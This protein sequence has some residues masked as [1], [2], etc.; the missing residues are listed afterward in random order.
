MFSGAAEHGIDFLLGAGRTTGHALTN[1]PAIIDQ[2]RIALEKEIDKFVAE[3]DQRKRR[4]SL[5]LNQYPIATSKLQYLA[6][7]HLQVAYRLNG[8]EEPFKY[9]TESALLKI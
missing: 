3:R 4:L 2:A 8:H 1:L 9:E 7:R 5:G 6:D